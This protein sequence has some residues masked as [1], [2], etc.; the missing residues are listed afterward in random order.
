MAARSAKV[1]ARSQWAR[2]W[3]LA[4]T[5]REYGTFV[6]PIRPVPPPSR[7]RHA[8]SGPG[9]GHSPLPGVSTALR[10]SNPTSAPAYALVTSTRTNATSTSTSPPHGSAASDCASLVGP[11]R[12]RASTSNTPKEGQVPALGSLSTTLAPSLVRRT[13]AAT[14]LQASGPIHRAATRLPSGRCTETWT[15]PGGGRGQSTGSTKSRQGGTEAGTVSAAG[16]SRTVS[17]SHTDRAFRSG[18]SGVRTAVRN[19]TF[20]HVARPP[21][22]EKRLIP[23]LRTFPTSA[24][25]R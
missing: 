4:P 20:C 16:R 8:T 18:P 22:P 17:P 7:F 6:T 23:P 2:T 13:L 14:P 25:P 19:S 9:P 5:G 12:L 1:Q 10:A 3:T 11:R 15:G 24:Q 21:A